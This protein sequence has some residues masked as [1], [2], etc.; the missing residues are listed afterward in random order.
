MYWLFATIFT[1]LAYSDAKFTREKIAEYGV[2]VEL[3]GAIRWLYSKFGPIGIDIG[4]AI[5][6]C[7]VADIG[8]FIP[9][10]LAFMLGVRFLLFILQW[11]I[12]H[13]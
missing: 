2:E 6:T 7:I 13:G 4:I 5:P 3:N 10:V 12:K 8:Y 11:K 9:T 1:L